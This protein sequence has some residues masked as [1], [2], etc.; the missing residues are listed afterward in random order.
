[1]SRRTVNWPDG[2]MSSPPVFV[3]CKAGDRLSALPLESV[4][5][6]MRPLPVEHLAG[7]PPYVAG[8]ARIR[9][10]AVPVVHAGALLGGGTTAPA[11]F[12]SL[13]VGA[14]RVALAVD[15]VV[16]V[17]ALPVATELPPLLAATH[18][19]IVA[20]VASADSTLLLILRAS[21]LLSDEVWA[22]FERE[23]AR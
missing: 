9:G 20:A 3:I 12:V 15:D 18:A 22:T 11:R 2:P 6:T 10:A 21:R 16:G 7:L 8:L 5:E 17:R 4:E 23:S 14:R 13:K 19:G 1:M